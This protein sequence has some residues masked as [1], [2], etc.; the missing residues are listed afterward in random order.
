MSDKI[1]P[2]ISSGTKG[3]LGVL[4]LPRLWQ[5]VSLEAAGKIADGYPGI[6]AGYDAMVIA[7]LGLDTEAVRAHITND[8]P[9]YPQFEAW[10][11]AQDGAKLDDASIGELNASI[12]GYNHDDATRQGI[13]SAN[14]LPDGD[15]KDAINLNNLDDWLEFHAAEIA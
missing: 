15:P 8:K 3:P 11:Q 5:K 14:G 12:E 2:L 10:I 9:T 4:H 7:G 13:L 1:V 6:G